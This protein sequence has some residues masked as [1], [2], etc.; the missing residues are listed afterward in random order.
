MDQDAAAAAYRRSSFENAPP[1][2]LVRM[3]YEG[4]VRFL[5]RAERATD[6][7]EAREWLRRV[8]AIVNEL[9]CSLDHQAAPEVSAN[10]ESLYLFVE[11][12]LAQATLNDEAPAMAEARGVL[13]TLLEGWN[14]AQVELD[15][16]PR[17]ASDEAA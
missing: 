1:I 17:S 9:R 8:E 11:A 15:G 4:A 5:E 13:A 12:R 14:G 16:L 10:L 6:A 7:R 2:K 3:L